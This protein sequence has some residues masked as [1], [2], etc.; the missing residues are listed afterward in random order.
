[1]VIH[2]IIVYAFGIYHFMF[3]RDFV[4]Y[5]WDSFILLHPIPYATSAQ[6]L[7]RE[8]TKSAQQNIFH[9][10]PYYLKE[11]NPL[12]KNSKIGSNYFLIFD[13]KK[14]RQLLTVLI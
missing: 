14:I 2:C 10:A 9:C 1:M 13:A 11:A 6:T 7:H 4:L 8:R 12:P 5:S 3:F